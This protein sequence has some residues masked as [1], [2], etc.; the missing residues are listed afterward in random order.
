MSSM[1]AM[2][3]PSLPRGEERLPFQFERRAARIERC[4]EMLPV[5]Q[6]DAQRG[7]TA[8]HVEGM[9]AFRD[10]ELRHRTRFTLMAGQR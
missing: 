5:L 6:H 8:Q 2:R 10:G 1:K 9:E 4:E 7:T 3:L